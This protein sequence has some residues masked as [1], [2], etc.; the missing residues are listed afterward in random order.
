MPEISAMQRK[1]HFAF[2]S[3]TICA[4]RTE[5]FDNIREIFAQ[6]R[7]ALIKILFSIFTYFLCLSY[8]SYMSY[9]S[10]LSIFLHIFHIYAIFV[11]FVIFVTFFTHSSYISYLSHLSFLRTYHP[12]QDCSQSLCR[13]TNIPVGFN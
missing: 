6:R 3:S 10:D 12:H 9:L 4:F 11:L 13:L 5:I 7:A 1:T 2:H 8:L